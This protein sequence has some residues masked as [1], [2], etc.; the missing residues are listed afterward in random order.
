MA[1]R[2]K[3]PPAPRKQ[4]ERKKGKYTENNPYAPPRPVRSSSEPDHRTASSESLQKEKMKGSRTSKAREEKAARQEH[5]HSVPAQMALA[6]GRAAHETRDQS[7]RGVADRRILPRLTYHSRYR[8]MKRAFLVRRSPYTHFS[9]HVRD[10]EGNRRGGRTLH[11]RKAP[12]GAQVR[13][14]FSPHPVVP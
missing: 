14:Q 12:Y 1:P 10:R 4:E 11:S 5:K 13:S 7:G 8:M 9:R 3:R 6:Y 2:V